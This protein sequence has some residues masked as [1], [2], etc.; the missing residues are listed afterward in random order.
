MD[1]YLAPA[2]PLNDEAPQPRDFRV[3]GL[4]VAGLLFLADFLRL[5]NQPLSL[6]DW[7]TRILCVGSGILALPLLL[8]QRWVR[9]SALAWTGFGILHLAGPLLAHAGGSLTRTVEALRLALLAVQLLLLLKPRLG[10]GRFLAGAILAVPMGLLVAVALVGTVIMKHLPLRRQEVRGCHLSLLGYAPFAKG[11]PEA[12]DAAHAARFRSSTTSLSLSMQ[13]G[14]LVDCLE[15]KPGADPDLAMTTN[16][17]L[18]GLALGLPL[19]KQPMLRPASHSGFQG[20]EA[21]WTRP[22]AGD[23]TIYNR[24]FGFRQASRFWMVFVRRTDAGPQEPADIPQILDSI[25][26]DPP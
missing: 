25:Q 6:V 12:P 20:L 1:E 11:V 17:E 2:S 18:P 23:R 14:I 21:V 24:L 5:F 3:W 19:S 9:I 16:L 13:A 8:G 15:A 22:A 26:I 7:P 10:F 4:R